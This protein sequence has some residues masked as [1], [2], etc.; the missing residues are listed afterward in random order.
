MALYGLKPKPALN[1]VFNACVTEPNPITYPDRTATCVRN[2]IELSQ[3][4][5]EGMSEMEEQRA[6]HMKDA[7]TKISYMDVCKA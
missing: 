3:L 5:G 4:D 2:S 6:R 1:Y 7:A